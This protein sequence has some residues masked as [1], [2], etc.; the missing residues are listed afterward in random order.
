MSSTIWLYDRGDESDSDAASLPDLHDDR[1]L[2]EYSTNFTFENHVDL[3]AQNYNEMAKQIVRLAAH[4]HR[5]Y[6]SAP[7]ASQ[8]P[9]SCIHPAYYMD[10]IGIASLNVLADHLKAPIDWGHQINVALQNKFVVNALNLFLS[11]ADNTAEVQC[12]S[13]SMSLTRRSM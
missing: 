2:D 5:Y 4:S 9:S 8:I 10:S 6:L 13:Q 3:N 11:S 12:L 1:Y 7:T